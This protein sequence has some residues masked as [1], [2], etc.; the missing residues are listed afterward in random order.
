MA[1]LVLGAVK[2][3]KRDIIRSISFPGLGG[4][5]SVWAHGLVLVCGN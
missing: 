2:E 3:V 5:S 4:E 1:F